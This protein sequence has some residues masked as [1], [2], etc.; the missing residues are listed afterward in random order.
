MLAQK[1]SPAGGKP[2]WPWADPARVDIRGVNYLRAGCKVRTGLA[3][4]RHLS[5]RA[6]PPLPPSQV[7]SQLP[8]SQAAVNDST[9]G[10]V[11]PLVHGL[12]TSCRRLQAV[13]APWDARE[14]SVPKAGLCVPTEVAPCTSP[15][16]EPPVLLKTALP[17]PGPTASLLLHRVTVPSCCCD[18]STPLGL[19]ISI[20]W[21][22]PVATVP[23]LLQS[24]LRRRQILLCPLVL[25]PGPWHLAYRLQGPSDPVS[26]PKRLGLFSGQIKEEKGRPGLLSLPQSRG[27]WLPSEVPKLKNRGRRRSPVLT[28]A[29]FPCGLSWKR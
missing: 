7:P 28:P 13:R 23:L 14:L 3:A 10:L 1:M 25:G 20:L 24:S 18:A 12:T 19:L 6:G 27:G 17:V 9:E 2:G 15:V 26:K 8:S 21:L 4:D 22:P 29:L 5:P 11:C 16:Q